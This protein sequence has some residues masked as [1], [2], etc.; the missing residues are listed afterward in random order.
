MWDNSQCELV[1]VN[2]QGGTSYAVFADSKAKIHLVVSADSM[3]QAQALSHR[4]FNRQCLLHIM[5]SSKRLA[6]TCFI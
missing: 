1:D 4:Q 5:R 6:K 2:L 3:S